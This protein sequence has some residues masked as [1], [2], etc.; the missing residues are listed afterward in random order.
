M[1]I[2]GNDIKSFCRSA[3][4]SAMQ[5]GGSDD[6]GGGDTSGGYCVKAPVT[7]SQWVYPDNWIP[8]VW[9]ENNQAVFVVRSVEGK[10]LTV[11]LYVYRTFPDSS[12][13]NVVS[14]DWGDGQTTEI[15]RSSTT[16]Y[17]SKA[18][19]TY[20]SGTGFAVTE[21][22]ET[23]QQWIITYNSY[24]ED[25]AFSGTFCGIVCS[26]GIQIQYAQFS[27]D[28][29]LG[30][31]HN[32]SSSTSTG[33]IFPNCKY[34]EY[35]GTPDIRNSFAGGCINL[36][37]VNYID[38][39]NEVGTR[40]LFN[41]CTNLKSLPKINFKTLGSEALASSG[42]EYFVCDSISYIDE[43]AFEDC[44]DLK[45]VVIPSSCEIHKTAFKNS[46][47]VNNLEIS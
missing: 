4:L 26:Y 37:Y 12:A 32:V 2:P 3:L 18:T 22:E 14:I 13:S 43:Y 35:I 31:I 7:A 29:K 41:G 30:E 1:I 21:D 34:L 10:T 39:G 8:R 5:D 16:K 17:V 44:S 23:Y 36:K 45:V 47:I 38:V 28:F 19:H 9:P 6:G 33:A 42:L 40:G 46:G 20:T 15:A 25:E 27:E 24:Y 11:T